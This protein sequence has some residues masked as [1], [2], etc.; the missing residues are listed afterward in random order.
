[1]LS[2]RLLEVLRCW[3]QR[4]PRSR[5]PAGQ[6]QKTSPEDWLFPGWRKDRHMNTATL[7]DACREAARAA[8]LTKRVSVHT[9]RHYAAS[10]TMPRG[11]ERSGLEPSEYRVAGAAAV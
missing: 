3:T 9:L 10:R 2:P 6:P 7:Q 11:S 8:G 4:V 5:S 1:M